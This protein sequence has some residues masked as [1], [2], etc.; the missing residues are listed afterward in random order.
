MQ[1]V[2]RTSGCIPKWE[3]MDSRCLY[4]KPEYYN[5]GTKY[6]CYTKP[7]CQIKK[8]KIMLQENDG[9]LAHVATGCNSVP[10]GPYW[11]LCVE[12]CKTQQSWDRG[13]RVTKSSWEC[14]H[15]KDLPE[16]KLT[17]PVLLCFAHWIS[18]AWKA[19]QCVSVTGN[20]HGSW[21][22]SIKALLTWVTPSRAAF[23]PNWGA[24]LCL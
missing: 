16:H 11:S 5:P 2:R 24:T 22:E 19:K 12:Y 8:K 1:T 3:K 23:P 18:S 13:L 10:V 21:Y 15:C 4:L 17:F 6:T 14:S 20:R 9:C 7:V